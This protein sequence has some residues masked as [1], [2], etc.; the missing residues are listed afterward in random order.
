MTTQLA[1]LPDPLEERFV[2]YHRDNPQILDRLRGLALQW[3]AAGHRKCSAKMLAEVLRWQHGLDDVTTDDD[4]KLNNS[5]VSRYA[6][7]ILQTTPALPS[8]FFDLRTLRT[9]RT[10]EYRHA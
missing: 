3:H 2:R 4:V 10:E 6:R 9:D 8:D 5:Y 1:L 7:L